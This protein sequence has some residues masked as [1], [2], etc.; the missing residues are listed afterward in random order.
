MPKTCLE[1]VLVIKTFNLL[2]DSEIPE[3]RG[4]EK[5]V[6]VKKEVAMEMLGITSQTSLQKLRNEGAIEYTTV[7]PKNIL[8]DRNSIND[9]LESK[10][11]KRFTI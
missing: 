2:I 5:T 7:L 11:Q 6:W 10:R 9:Y 3:Y 8:Y 4:R 1:E